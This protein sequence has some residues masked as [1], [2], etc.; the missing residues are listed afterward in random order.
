MPRPG[1][2]RFRPWPPRPTVPTHLP[3]GIRLNG[4]APA[5][6]LLIQLVLLRTGHIIAAMGYTIVSIILGLAGRHSATG[7]YAR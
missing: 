4:H 2:R 7:Y 6:P 1:P 5:R 3:T